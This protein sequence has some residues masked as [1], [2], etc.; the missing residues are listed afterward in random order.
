[1]NILKTK[2]NFWLY[3]SK[4]NK[5]GQS[6]IYMRIIVGSSKTE[7]STG[8][9]VS[10]KNWDGNRQVIR[11]REEDVEMLNEKLE[12]LKKKFKQSFKQLMEL[13][14]DFTPE[15]IKSR[16]LGENIEFKTL[17]QLFTSHNAKM[18]ELEGKDYAPATL[19]RY[20]TTLIHVQNFLKHKFNQSDILISQLNLSFLNEF[21]HYFKVVRG[22]NHNSAVKY[23][24]NLRRVINSAL[25]NQYISTDPFAGYKSKIKPVT[26]VF[27]TK[28]ELSRIE[29]KIFDI[30]RLESV[31]KIFLFQVYSGLSYI[32]LKN[33]QSSHIIDLLGQQWIFTTRTKSKIPVRVP[34]I[35][36]IR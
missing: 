6:P 18:K 3:K 15:M 8:I 32:D 16:M 7:L 10:S 9:F 35:V 22:C 2:Y 14:T 23:I 12:I 17:L 34:L 20:N 13:E 33:L 1:M 5:K 29:G 28:D 30:P 24:K 36:S 21:E 27:L 26:T 4:L 19:K 25:D 11:D 31:K